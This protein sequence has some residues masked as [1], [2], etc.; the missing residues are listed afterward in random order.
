[1]FVATLSA[2]SSR[3]SF[4]ALL[5]V[6]VFVPAVSSAG[7]SPAEVRAYEAHKIKA[8]EGNADSQYRL[9]L[10]YLEGDG[11]S[12]DAKLAFKWASEAATKGHLAAQTLRGVAL[13][14]GIGVSAD[15]EAGAAQTLKAAMLGDGGA[16]HNYANWCM[17]GKGVLKDE[18]EA[19]A[20]FNLAA[21]SET[22]SRDMRDFLDRKLSET[23]RLAGQ[24]RARE[25]KEQIER[26]KK[27]L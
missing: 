15:Q 19:Y 25:L 5:G 16:Q 6:L 12:K 18:V 17:D 24:K 7:L 11:T 20:F 26:N 8:L 2:S 14:Y 3:W 4:L 13:Y 23:S 1:M 22:H 27:G 9:A 10:C 21:V